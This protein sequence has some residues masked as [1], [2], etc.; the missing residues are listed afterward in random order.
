MYSRS[1]HIANRVIEK[2]TGNSKKEE[3][4][5]FCG[6]KFEEL[7]IVSDEIVIPGIKI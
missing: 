5:N 6:N 2:I 4:E 3:V 1:G 7:R